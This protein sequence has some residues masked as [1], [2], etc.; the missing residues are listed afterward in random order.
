MRTN[1]VLAR[2]GAQSLHP[3]WIDPAQSRTWDLRLVPYQPIPSQD[4]VDCVVGE[5][6]PGPK[7]S[8]IRQVL[9]EWDGW[10]SYDRI[11]IPDD[12]IRAKQDVINKMFEVA[13]ALG[14]ELFA[15]ALDET[16]YYAHFITMR[17]S[18]FYGRWVG[19]VEIMAPGFRTATLERLLSTLDLTETGWGWGLDSVWPKLLGYENVGIIDGT[20]V[21]HTRPVGQMRDAN[22]RK[23]V[24]EESD[25]LLDLYDCAQ[26]H[27]TFGAFGDDL[28][29]LDLSPERLLVD[30]VKGWE[31]L[32]DR[33]PRILSWIV[34]FH[35]QRFS[36]LDYPVQGTPG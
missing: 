5:V 1:L 16:S 30:V 8:G 21:T 31:Y 26:V 4:G 28:K 22:L 10:R 7:W 23:R 17:N 18:S 35:R 34:D 25:K 32:V 14:L 36:A 27:T 3:D 24:L 13:D 12:D 9:N 19:F 2:V 11:W 15:P 29:R 20:A 6:I 33:D